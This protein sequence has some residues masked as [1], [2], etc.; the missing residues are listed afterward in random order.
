M[1]KAYTDEWFKDMSKALRARDR[2]NEMIKR[3]QAK[4]TEAE[5]TID[6]LSIGTTTPTEPAPVQE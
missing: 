2:A 3:W 1:T 6:A 5:A 4:V